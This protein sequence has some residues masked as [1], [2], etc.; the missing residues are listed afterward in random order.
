MFTCLSVFR[1]KSAHSHPDYIL[2]VKILQWC[3]VGVVTFI[4]L[5]DH[6]L[7]DAVQ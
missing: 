3:D 4:V 7:D 1:G 2:H 6:L 5:Q